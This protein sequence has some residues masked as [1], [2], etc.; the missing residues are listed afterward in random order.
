MP[1]TAFATP[2]PTISSAE[3]TPLWPTRALYVVNNTFVKDRAAGGTCVRYGGTATVV[4]RNNLLVGAG[5]LLGGTGGS[6]TMEGNLPVATFPFAD[7]AGYAD[8]VGCARGVRGDGP[9]AACRAPT[10]APPRRAAHARAP[11]KYRAPKIV[12]RP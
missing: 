9:R 3:E 2:T 4:L 7:Q 8:L 1:T 5:T 11:W 12:R 10:V 6:V